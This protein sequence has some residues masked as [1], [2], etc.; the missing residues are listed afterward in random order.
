MFLEFDFVVPKSAQ[1]FNGTGKHIE[2]QFAG[3]VVALTGLHDSVLIVV[4]NRRYLAEA[5]EAVAGSPGLRLV[6]T[7]E[8]KQLRDLQ[9]HE[10][11]LHTAYAKILRQALPGEHPTPYREPASPQEA[12][13]LSNK[14]DRRRWQ[15]LNA[16]T[17]REGTALLASETDNAQ[18]VTEAYIRFS[19]GELQPLQAAE[20]IEK[21]IESARTRV[22]LIVLRPILDKQ[23]DPALTELANERA[24]FL[25]AVFR[26]EGIA[27]DRVVIGRPRAI[28]FSAETSD[29]M[30]RGAVEVSFLTR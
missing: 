24:R 20:P 4:G 27:I 18:L 26:S 19:P 7:P 15:I 3:R 2:A 23:T 28:D 5:T 22:G 6:E 25:A 14:E 13:L 16:G 30:H 1:F 12:E 10:P 11:P 29:S 8:I 17:T 9:R 21:M